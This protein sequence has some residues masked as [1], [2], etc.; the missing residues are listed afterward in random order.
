LVTAVGA[1]HGR[2]KGER[3]QVREEWEQER[4]RLAGE[5][6]VEFGA[7][8]SSPPGDAAIWLV[9]GLITVADWIGSD[10]THFPQVACW[11]MPERRRRA[12][13][14]LAAIDWR[15]VTT[16]QLNGFGDLFPEIPRPNSLQTA[17]MDVVSEP[18][19]YVVEGPMGYGKTEAAL[20]AAYHLIAGG[21]RYY[22]NAVV[23]KA[24]KGFFILDE[25]SH[26]VSFF[27]SKAELNGA[28]AERQL[29]TPT[30]PQMTPDDGWRQVWGPLCLRS[31][32]APAR[33]ANSVGIDFPFRRFS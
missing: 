12:Q 21:W 18:G 30:A 5:L 16:R 26:A 3:V 9:A 14:A 11:A 33:P 15:A 25:T 17:T 31:R 13:T 8:P 4:L 32:A 20:A 24:K 23:G 19:V 22:R 1:H 7:L 29:G 6:I 2:I 10:E 27:V 28:I